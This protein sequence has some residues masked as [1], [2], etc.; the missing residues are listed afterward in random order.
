VIVGGGTRFFPPGVRLGLRLVDERA[1]DD[2]FV[3][4]HYAVR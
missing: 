2:G 3:A 1:F 4:L